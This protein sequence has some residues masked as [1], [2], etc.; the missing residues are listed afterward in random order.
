MELLDQ[1]VDEFIV[2][3]QKHYGVV[4][5]RDEAIKKGRQLIRLVE[6]VEC[7]VN[8]NEYEGRKEQ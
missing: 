5:E 7:E 3:Y 2:L 1:H 8:T 6:L 4:L